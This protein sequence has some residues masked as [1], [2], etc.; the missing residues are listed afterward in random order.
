MQAIT[1]R[2]PEVLRWSKLYLKYRLLF[3]YLIKT[4]MTQHL[5]DTFLVGR[6][7]R[8]EINRQ[9]QR[10]VF[11]LS[12]IVQNESTNQ[13]ALVRIRHLIFLYPTLPSRLTPRSFWASTANS[14]GSS[15]KTSLQKPLT[16]METASSVE[17]PRWLQ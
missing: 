16:I 5:K 17:M 4:E 7:T 10:S 2:Q 14:I 12:M 1:L 8:L 15:R 3:A 9:N 13:I 6:L 11:K